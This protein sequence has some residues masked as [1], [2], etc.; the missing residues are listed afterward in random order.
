MADPA[1]DPFHGAA[2]CPGRELPKTPTNKIQKTGL[3]E[4]GVTGA[5]D[6]EAAGL[7]V[8]RENFAN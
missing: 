5:F 8:R 1:H 2:L 7:R 6:R 3:R 4:E